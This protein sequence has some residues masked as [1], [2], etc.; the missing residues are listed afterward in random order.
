MAEKQQELSTAMQNDKGTPESVKK[1]VSKIDGSIKVIEAQAKRLEASIETADNERRDI[2]EALSEQATRIELMAEEYDELRGSLARADTS[3]V[4]EIVNDKLKGLD[5]K[6]VFS[7]GPD[8][9][10][11]E[12][13]V[14]EKLEVINERYAEL[15]RQHTSTVKQLETLRKDSEKDI[16][17]LNTRTEDLERLQVAGGR[18]SRERSV[19]SEN[20]LQSSAKVKPP[21]FKAEAKDKPMMYF[22]ALQRYVNAVNTDCEQVLCIIAASLEG[23]GTRRFPAEWGLKVEYGKYDVGSKWTRV[24][25]ASYIWG[26]AKELDISYT[27]SQLVAKIASHFDWDIR[28]T[29][30]TQEIKSHTKF[31]DLLSFK[32]AD[33]PRQRNNSYANNNSR[34]CH[35]NANGMSAKGR[36]ED[37]KQSAPANNNKPWQASKSGF[38]KYQHKRADVNAIRIEKNRTGKEKVD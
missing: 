2:T 9:A 28:Y 18:A 29:V 16:D 31:F 27:E 14:E 19:S 25:Y 26:F 15:R 23:I 13:K 5:A 4:D 10:V 3:R 24:E 22:R 20:H 38:N 8:D 36:D 1:W 30:S 32:D 12:T 17:E 7:V 33:A 35:E 37:S 34:N 11:V 6:Y 21:V